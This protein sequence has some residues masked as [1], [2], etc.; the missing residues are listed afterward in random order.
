MK[1]STRGRYATRALLELALHNSGGTATLKDIA[2][3]QNIS[4]RY[5]EHLITPLIAAGL[6]RTTRGPRGGI[7]LA[8][9][10]S[11][12]KL[13]EVIQLLEGSIAPV[14]CVDNPTVC[15]RADSCATRDIWCQVRNA[16][17]KVLDSVTLLDLV[18]CHKKKGDTEQAMYYV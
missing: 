4:L 15:S 11:E 12:I 9:A 2:Q 14:E 6:V 5:L 10:P 8:K 3:R 16:V 13:S 18:E 7:S 1:L 17:T